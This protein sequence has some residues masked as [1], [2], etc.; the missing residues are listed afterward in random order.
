[1]APVLMIIKII[2]EKADLN[3]YATIII[4]LLFINSGDVFYSLIS[5]YYR[6]IIDVYFILT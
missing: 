3:L 5:I 1:M 2:Y 6:Y 4:Y